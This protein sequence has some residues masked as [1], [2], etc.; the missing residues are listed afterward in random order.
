MT[1][2]LTRPSDTCADCRFFRQELPKQSNGECRRYPPPSSGVRFGAGH[3]DWP[4]TLP[5]H[6]CGEYVFS[7]RLAEKGRTVTSTEQTFGQ[8]LKARRVERGLTLRDVE[9]ITGG[10]ISNAALS[11]IE[12]GKTENPGFTTVVTLAAALGLDTRELIHRA[13]HGNK[14]PLAPDFCPHCGQ[15]MR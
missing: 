14:P 1:G 9:R 7:G 6:W 3:S 4:M 2:K 5:K 13:R 10:A 11:Q 12:T 8:W 15:V